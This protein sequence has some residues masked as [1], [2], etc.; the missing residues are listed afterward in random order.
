MIRRE[1]ILRDFFLKTSRFR[2]RRDN[3]A[4]QLF[5]NTS[6]GDLKRNQRSRSSKITLDGARQIARE[7][8][9]GKSY[10]IK[11]ERTDRVVIR[12]C[13]GARVVLPGD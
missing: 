12:E 2:S 9:T 7:M 13:N 8:R 4:D 5:D 11:I 3:D 6:G 1:T 10:A